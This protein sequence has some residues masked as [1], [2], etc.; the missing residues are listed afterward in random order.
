MF[1]IYSCKFNNTPLRAI[2][3]YNECYVE[4]EIIKNDTKRV[5]KTGIH[6]LSVSR[7]IVKH[8]NV[9]QRIMTIAVRCIDYKEVEK[10]K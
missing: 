4:R 7:Y 1:F 5:Q 3:I 9:S 8:M 6:C 2:K 10:F